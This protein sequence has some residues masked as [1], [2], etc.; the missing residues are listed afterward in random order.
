MSKTI[1][2]IPIDNLQPNPLQPRGVITPESLTDLIESIRQHGI[3]EPLIVAKTPA[4]YQI[5]AGERRWRSA[6]ILGLK[7]VPIIIR[8]TTPRQM[9]ELALIEN[10]QRENLNPLER[11]K[12]FQQLEEEFD[13]SLGEISKKISKSMA[14]ISNSIRLLALPDAVKDG[15][16]SG[17]ISEGHARA[18]AGLENNQKIINIYKQILKEKGSVRRAEELTRLAKNQSPQPPAANRPQ[19]MIKGYEKISN[20]IKNSLDD[21]EATKVAISRSRS[22]TKITIT[23]QGGIEETEKKLNK[24]YRKFTIEKLNPQNQEA[25]NES[26]LDQ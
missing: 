9:L 2:E 19:K 25:N 14:Y 10:V 6:K 26:R 20:K 4:G 11:A 12:A 23:F 22:Q 1:T 17:L 15:L 8:K 7:T 24:F 3:V 18:I 13:L 21:S 16:L 5:I